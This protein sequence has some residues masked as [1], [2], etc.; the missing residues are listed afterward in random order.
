[1]ETGKYD[2]N[3]TA[4]P[5]TKIVSGLVGGVE[6]CCPFNGS[7]DENGE[8]TG[9]NH[10]YNF[11][12]ERRLMECDAFRKIEPDNTRIQITPIIRSVFI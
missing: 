8:P 2:R 5:G 9:P 12:S 10:H 4:H 1:M 3:H 11:A 7:Y 6:Y